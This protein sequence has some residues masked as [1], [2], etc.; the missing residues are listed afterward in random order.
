M[1]L[2]S[3][4]NT[5]A[6]RLIM[7]NIAGI[8]DYR[9]FPFREVNASP[10]PFRFTRDPSVEQKYAC[11]FDTIE[12]PYYG[13]P[14][15]ADFDSFL[16][17]LHTTAFIVIKDDVILYEKYFHGHSR[18]S[19]ERTFSISK[20]VTSALV[21]IAVDEGLIRSIDDPVTDY[22]PEIKGKG[23]DAVTIKNLLMMTSGLKFRA[24][25]LPWDEETRYY[26]EPRLRKLVT[27]DLAVAEPPG[28][29]FNYNDYHAALLGI[30]LEKVTHRTVSEFLQE[31]I[32]TPLGME[33][34]ATWSLNSREDGLESMASGLNARAIDMAKF[35]TLY[36]DKGLWNG[37]RIISERW[38]TES[39]SPEAHAGSDY[40][41]GWYT[42]QNIYYK[43]MWWG[44]SLGGGDYNFYAY[45]FL[46]QM[47]YICPKKRIVIARFGKRIGP[48]DGIAR[49]L[50]E[51]IE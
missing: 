13:R 20:S 37:H 15:M 42:G 51:I 46:G 7:W 21:G 40:Y 1:A 18:D 49:R 38:V 44:H 30:I 33:Y 4:T 9:K 50:C 12:Y 8:E 43:Y 11:V 35:A 6:G 19:I 3:C 5:Y 24:G 14:K 2:P 29:H 25:F 17:S 16:A 36:L 41:P 26:Y 45:G 48:W 34:P 28:R 23:L 39:V 47:L 22:I 31:K 10:A 27:T 32:W